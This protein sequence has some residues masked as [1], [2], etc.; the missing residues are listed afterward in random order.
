M[1][2]SLLKVKLIPFVFLKFRVKIYVL[3]RNGRYSLNPRPFIS[4]V[5]VLIFCIY[6]S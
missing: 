6:V 1:N 5:P 3:D 4:A 2:F